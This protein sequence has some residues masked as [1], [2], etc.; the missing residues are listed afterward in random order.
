[1]AKLKNPLLSLDARNTLA[2]SVTFARRR[3][4]NIAEK[5]PIPTDPKSLAQM[6][7][8]WDYQDG[9]WYWQTLNQAQKQAYQTAASR[10]HM[11]GF[12]YF[13]RYYLKNLPDLAGRWRLDEMGGAV[14]YD[15]SKNNNNGV[16]VGASPATGVI[17]GCL[18]FDGLNDTVDC[19]NHPSIKD[20][21]YFTWS[22]F[23]KPYELNREQFLMGK[24]TIANGHALELRADNT[25]RLAAMI[26]GAYQTCAS[27]T[28][29][30]AADLQKWHHVAG[31]FDGAN[32]KIFYEGHLERTVP[33][34]GTADSIAL[35][36][37]LGS[38]PTP[39]KFFKGAPDD[40]RIQ[41]RAL[42]GPQILA[43]SERRYPL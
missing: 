40:I 6:Y 12:A 11:T 30:T 17:D 20:L 8:R 43:L 23:F 1:M 22:C 9:I 24:R 36:F 7:Q 34:A 18:Y 14:A 42:A 33:Q 3:Q 21:P 10:Y 29:L 5:K 27:T 19:G 35:D 38:S 31:S 39:L 28:V 37:H 41:N 25:V 16:I 4:Q 2:E 15:S 32:L 13:M 26:S